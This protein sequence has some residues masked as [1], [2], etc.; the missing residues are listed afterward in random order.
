MG[1]MPTNTVSSVARSVSVARGSEKLRQRNATSQN[2]QSGKVSVLATTDLS[3]GQDV[4]ILFNSLTLSPGSQQDLA[5]IAYCVKFLQLF[6]FSLVQLL[7]LLLCRSGSWPAQIQLKRS[8]A[9]FN[10]RHDHC[11]YCSQTHPS[12]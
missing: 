9:Q 3:Q 2:L 6:F 11:S 1:R 8:P 7:D 10:T 5:S 4:D 12:A